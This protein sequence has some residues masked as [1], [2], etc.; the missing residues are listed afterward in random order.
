MNNIEKIKAYH[1][2][3]SFL[4]NDQ[5]KILIE[6]LNLQDENLE[7]RIP[8]LMVEDEFAL[9]LHFLDNCKHI[10]SIDETTAFLTTESYQNDFILYFKNN[11][12]IMV[13]V[14][15]TQDE[16][17]KI[18][19]K[20]VSKKIEFAKEL[21]FEL[22]FVLKMRNFWTMYH[23]KYLIENDCKINFKKDLLKSEFQ[24]VLNNKILIVP[25]NIRTESLYD[26]GALGSGLIFIN[27]KYGEL[28]N[29]KLFYE[30][31]LIFEVT[32]ENTEYYQHM[33]MLECWHEMMAK[34]ES[35]IQ[36]NEYQTLVKDFSDELFMTF[37]FQYFLSSMKT[38]LR[39][40]D[41]TYHSSSFL[42]Y[43]V[44]ERDI[45]INKNLLY[46]VLND[47]IKLGIPINILDME[48]YK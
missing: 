18:S 48:K 19:Q 27:Y 17:F 22:Y 26:K 30:E 39:N 43:L 42:K 12:K 46:S 31:K 40:K 2:V 32:P 4:D 29:F 21:G 25:K 47:I 8:G 33:V 10:I 35:I 36:L 20:I 23:S 45:F 14:K 13:E 11:S 44:E 16:N 28:I 5:K 7:K 9:I 6:M 34:N 38:S 1:E 37:D 15:S 24:K 41:N 3:E